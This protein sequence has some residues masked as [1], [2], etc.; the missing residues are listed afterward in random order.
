MNKKRKKILHVVGGMDVGGTET[1][2]MNLYRKVSNEFEF[3]FISYYDYKGY[4]DDEI[5]SLGGKVIRLKKYSE[6]GILRNIKS[7]IKVIKDDGSYEVVH[8]H[9]LFNCGIAMFAARLSGIKI[10][11]SHAHTTLDNSEGILKK[12]YIK[13]MR[14][15]INIFSTNQLYCSRRA[16]EYL[17][18]K[19]YL[20]DKGTYFPNLI[21]YPRFIKCKDKEIDYFKKQQQIE[22]TIV[23]GHI[24]RFVEAKNHKFLIKILKTMNEK[25]INATLLLAG[26][27]YMKEDIKKMAVE[28]KVYDKIR[29][30]G[31]REDIDIVLK[32]MDVFIFP[33]IYEGLGLVMLEAQASGI[34]CVV[35]EAIQPEADLGLGLVT[36]LSLEENIDKWI[37]EILEANNRRIVDKNTIIKAFKEN[38]Y[39]IDESITKL[40]N[41][42]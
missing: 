26:N 28:Y 19:R 33:S 18:G 1:M 36:K 6:L 3:H 38:G 2:L 32:A 42:Y 21:D 34:P 20:N 29:F 27:G 22:D 39:S 30:L 10:R 13:L 31:I 24:G 7:L 8:A 25:N 17:F 12:I 23:L 37:N 14:S 41:I 15:I 40:K 35:S 4:Y 5:I 16:G 11:I 9:T